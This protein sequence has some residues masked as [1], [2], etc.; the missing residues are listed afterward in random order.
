[1]ITKGFGTVSGSGV[2]SSTDSKSLT[3]V[4]FQSP[5]KLLLLLESELPTISIFLELRFYAT[6]R[7]SQLLMMYNILNPMMAARSFMVFMV[8]VSIGCLADTIT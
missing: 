5:E 8:L 7:D 6:F 3:I 4:E 1:L 2:G